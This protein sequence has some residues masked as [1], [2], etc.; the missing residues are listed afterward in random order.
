MSWVAVANVDD[1][2]VEDVIEVT[3]GD[4]VLAVY[5]GRDGYYCTDGICTHERAHLGDGVVLGNIIECPKH[6]GR[7]DVRTGEPKGPPVHIP[8]RTYP[9]RVEAGVIYVDM[10]PSR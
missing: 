5:H 7:F 10:E 6:Q 2:D 9:T 8:V 4:K 3:L 1:I